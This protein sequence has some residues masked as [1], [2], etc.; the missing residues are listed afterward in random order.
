MKNLSRYS[1]VYVYIYIYI[2]ID[3]YIEPKIHE[4]GNTLYVIS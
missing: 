2:Y 4:V 3:I 1:C